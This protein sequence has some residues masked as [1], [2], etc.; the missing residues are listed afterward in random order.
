MEYLRKRKEEHVTGRGTAGNT[1]GE[2]DERG[3]V[4]GAGLGGRGTDYVWP[5]RM[6]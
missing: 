6:L 2:M 1:D 4:S 3:R 5:G